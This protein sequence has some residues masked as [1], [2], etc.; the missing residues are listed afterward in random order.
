MPVAPEQY[1]LVALGDV[2]SLPHVWEKVSQR[3]FSEEK[4]ALFIIGTGDYPADG[5]KYHEW[6]EQFFKPARS[7]LGH[8]PIWPAIGNTRTHARASGLR[9]HA[10]RMADRPRP[11]LFGAAL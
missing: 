8:M 1:R 2:R 5:S 4:D 7:L 9:R 10:A 3:V 11:A 6:I